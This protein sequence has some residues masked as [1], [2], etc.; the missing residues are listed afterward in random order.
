MWTFTNYDI[1]RPLELNKIVGA[2]FFYFNKYRKQMG[3]IIREQSGSR[4]SN[5]SKPDRSVTPP[6]LLP[7]PGCRPLKR[8]VMEV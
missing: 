3:K 4:G 2:H 1:L 8:L 7:Q 5:G 6:G